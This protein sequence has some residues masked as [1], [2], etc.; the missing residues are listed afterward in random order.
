MIVRQELPTDSDLTALYSEELFNS[1]WRA[2][3]YYR[4]LKTQAINCRRKWQQVQKLSPNPGRLLDV[5]TAF[6]FFL[7][8]APAGWEVEGCELSE[9]ACEQGKKLNSVAIRQGDFLNISYP[10]S[11][12][13]VITMWDYLEH[14][15]DPL[16]NLAK[17]RR[18]LRAGGHLFLT[19]GNAESR[20][21]RLLG[22]RWRLVKPSQHLYCFT[23]TA[24]EKML[25][26]VGLRIADTRAESRVFNLSYLLGT[27]CLAKAPVLG[28]GVRLLARGLPFRLRI[29]LGDIMQLAAEAVDGPTSSPSEPVGKTVAADG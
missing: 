14:V 12:F 9:F 21:A 10:E 19:T 11:S 6:G 17:A 18:L 24:I 26:R 1:P 28:A 8:H 5:G 3:Y 13:D 29:C 2:D 16:A 27:S 15:P 25:S 4:D 7:K 23:L 20:L 22:R